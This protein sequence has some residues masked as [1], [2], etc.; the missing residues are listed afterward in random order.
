MQL[1]ALEGLLDRL[2]R[3]PHARSLVLKGGALLAAFDARRPTRDIDLAAVDVSIDLDHI[4]QLIKRDGRDA[5]RRRSS[6]P[7]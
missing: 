5:G 3:S 6:T 7:T 4:R 1:Y 2:S